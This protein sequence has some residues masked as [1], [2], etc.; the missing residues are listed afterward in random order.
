MID[1]ATRPMLA[2]LLLVAAALSGAVAAQ[3]D[4]IPVV[5]SLEDGSE[6]PFVIERYRGDTPFVR[7]H[8]GERGALGT[9]RVERDGEIVAVPIEEVARIDR[10]R[11][12]DV[13]WFVTLRDGTVL[14]APSE[15]DGAFFEM[16]GVP[17]DGSRVRWTIYVGRNEQA[18]F[19]G[20]IFAPELGYSVPS[21]GADTR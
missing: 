10:I 3:S 14:E 20:V 17:S 12:M 6:Q 21:G 18:P 2:L 13:R 8:D 5:L 1:R 7:F 4:G 15:S 11:F 19:V 9:F 16:A